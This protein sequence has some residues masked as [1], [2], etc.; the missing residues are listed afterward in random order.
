MAMVQVPAAF[1][2]HVD[3]VEECVD[4]VGVE[5]RPGKSTIARTRQPDVY[6]ASQLS[7]AVMSPVIVSSPACD[8]ML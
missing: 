1:F 6:A 4:A 5:D 2:K 7:G 3:V 8:S